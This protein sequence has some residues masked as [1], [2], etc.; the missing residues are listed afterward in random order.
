MEKRNQNELQFLS[1]LALGHDDPIKLSGN[2]THG[3]GSSILKA[4]ALLYCW[5]KAAITNKPAT[6]NGVRTDWRIWWAH[7]VPKTQV[8]FVN[9]H[10]KDHRV[11]PFW[12]HFLGLLSRSLSKIY[13]A[14]SL[15]S[16]QAIKIRGSKDHLLHSFFALVVIINQ[17]LA[18]LSQGLHRIHLD[19]IGYNIVI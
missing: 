13:T 10:L 17:L 4:S 11:F 8:L 16:F 7:N 6:M 5:G 9:A 1:C 19:W 14:R 12:W 3:G 2:L 18:I 15:T